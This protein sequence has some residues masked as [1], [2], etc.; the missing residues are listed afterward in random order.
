MMGRVLVTGAAGFAGQYL[1]AHLAERGYRVFG[2]RQGRGSE[3]GDRE[4]ETFKCDL[5]DFAQI[6][7]VVQEVKPDYVVHLAAISYVAHA[8][9]AE[10]YETNIIGSRN[11]LCSLDLLENKPQSIVLTSSANIYGNVVSELI[12]EESTPAPENDYAV[13]K[14]AMEYMSRIFAPNLNIVTVRPFNYTGRG[15]SSNFLTPKIV[16]HFKSGAE[17]IE[18]GNLDVFRDISDVRVVVRYIR[19]LME[20]PTAVGQIFNICSERGTS[21]QMIIKYCEMIAGRKI[22]VEIN[23]KF[24]RENEIKRLVGSRRKLTGTVGAIDDIDL[25]ATLRWMMTA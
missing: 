1:C 11:L 3:E 12:S 25:E 6:N 20:S 23:P 24:V 4:S 16:D 8:D 15:Q 19:L 21:V 13:S 18:L 7:R 5:R 9:T 17:K 14:I 22:V 10:I 2:T